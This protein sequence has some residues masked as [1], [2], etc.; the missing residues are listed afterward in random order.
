MFHLTQVLNN[1]SDVDSHC[2]TLRAWHDATAREGERGYAEQSQA[3]PGGQC[4]RS[5][6]S[7]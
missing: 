5:N 2:G 3:E 6:T 1:A 4:E 7:K